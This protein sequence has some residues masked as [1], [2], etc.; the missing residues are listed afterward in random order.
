MPSQKSFL[1]FKRLSS[2]SSRG[3]RAYEFTTAINAGNEPYPSAVVV[4][5][6]SEDV[7]SVDRGAEGPVLPVRF[8]QIVAGEV[9]GDVAR[10]EDEH[11]LPG[12]PLTAFFSPQVRLPSC[13]VLSA[14]QKAGLDGSSVTCIQRKASGEIL[15]LFRK[16]DLKERFVCFSVLKV[17]GAP[18]AIQDGDHPLTFV[19]I[20]DAPHELPDSAII[21]RVADYCKV[22]TYRRS[23]FRDPGWENVQDGSRHYHVCMKKPIPS[24]MG[25]G[26]TFIQF[27]YVGQ[28]KTCRH[29]HSASHFANACHTI[30]CFNCKKSGHLASDCPAPVACNI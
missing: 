27:R 23:F 3:A 20:F 4:D 7:V 30:I 8:N 21:Q 28:P 5:H 19:Q 10:P 16:A 9:G 6:S 2:V 14:L 11:R 15:L 25:F 13:D 12:R 1:V 29:C 18:Y 22:V 26:N 17:N 24:Y